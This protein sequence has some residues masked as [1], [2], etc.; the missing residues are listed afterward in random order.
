MATMTRTIGPAD[1]GRRISFID[2]I[3]ADFEEEY[4]GQIRPSMKKA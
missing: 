2:F 4:Q 3:D 1:H